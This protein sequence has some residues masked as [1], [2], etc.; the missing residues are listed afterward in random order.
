[1]NIRQQNRIGIATLILFLSTPSLAKAQ[2]YG[3]KSLGPVSASSSAPT[4]LFR[5]LENGTGFNDIG[6]VKIGGADIDG[7]GLA[8]SSTFGLMGYSLQAGGS[9]LISINPITAVASPIGAALSGRNIRGAVFDMSNQLRV[10]DV[11]NQ[12]LLTI[13]PVTGGVQSAVNLSTNINDITDIAQSPDGTFY[14]TSGPP[15]GAQF[16]TLNPNT[17]ALTPV[18][19]DTTPRSGESVPPAVAGLAFSNNASPSSLFAYDVNAFDDIFL[20][21]VPGFTRTDE[22]LNIISSFN[23]GRG[24]LASLVTA[25]ATPEPGL[26]AMLTGLAVSGAAF[27]LKRRQKR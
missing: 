10:L 27:A 3:L 6:P 18:F 21:T 5:F 14:V 24:D 23:A 9:T 12:Q 8:L 2:V 7:D 11:S 13:D 16:Y 25:P 26:S 19:L 4:H 20:Y 1:M 22:F 15:S 17:G